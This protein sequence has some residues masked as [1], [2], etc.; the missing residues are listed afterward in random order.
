MG[1]IRCLDHFDKG[2]CHQLQAHSLFQILAASYSCHS[3]QY[4]LHILE[5]ILCGRYPTSP[6]KHFKLTQL[7]GFLPPHCQ[8]ACGKTLR[9]H[10]NDP[11]IAANIGQ[12]HHHH[13]YRQ[14]HHHCYH[15]LQIFILSSTS[16][17]LQ[18]IIQHNVQHYLVYSLQCIVYSAYCLVHSAQS[19]VQ[20]AK[21]RVTSTW[22]KLLRVV[23]SVILH[24]HD[25]QCKVCSAICT[26]YS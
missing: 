14:N 20:R 1:A 12:H 19:L 10:F 22:C 8:A 16:C 5:D 4:L 7:I 26:V 11:T 6:R 2:S 18:C 17:L 23:L 13:H 9:M 25:A 3:V 24:A 21:S 15:H